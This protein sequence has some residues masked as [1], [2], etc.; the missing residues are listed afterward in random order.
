[1]I[2]DRSKLMGKSKPTL[3][4]ESKETE[5]GDTD[6]TKASVDIEHTLEER[7]RKNKEKKREIEMVQFRNYLAEHCEPGN[8]TDLLKQRAHNEKIKEL[9]KQFQD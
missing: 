3:T 2:V 8:E 5:G 6:R 1:M 7:K 9:Y 4:V